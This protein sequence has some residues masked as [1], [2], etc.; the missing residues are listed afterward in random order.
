MAAMPVGQMTASELRTYRDALKV[1]L[2]D[3]TIGAAQIARDLR[4]DLA[5]ANTEHDRGKQAERESRQRL[6]DRRL[7]GVRL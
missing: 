5:A 7:N 2:A 1:A 4:T 3:K 6:R